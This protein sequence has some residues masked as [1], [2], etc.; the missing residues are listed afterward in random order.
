MISYNE[1]RQLVYNALRTP[2]GTLLVSYY[3][4]DYKAHKDKNGTVYDIDGGL[5]YL[6][7]TVIGDEELIQVY[8]DEPFEKVRK[9]FHWGAL[10]NKK[11]KWIPLYKLKNDHLDALCLYEKAE[12]FAR[13]LFIK[14]KQY[15]QLT[16]ENL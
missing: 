14:E 1:H 5:S 7:N 2:D 4:H 8:D 9:F 15:R 16:L 12:T 13:I 3:R 10:I 6:H 11:R